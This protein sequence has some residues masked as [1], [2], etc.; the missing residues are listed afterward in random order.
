MLTVAGSSQ[1]SN[2]DLQASG[3][4]QIVFSGPLTYDGSA[5]GSSITTLG[6]ESRIDLSGLTSFA[7]SDDP[8]APVLVHA[9]QNGQIKLAGPLAGSIEIVVDGAGSQV[10]LSSITA[11]GPGKLTAQNDAQLSLP[12]TIHE[13]I[14]VSIFADSTHKSIFHTSRLIEQQVP[15]HRSNGSGE[16]RRF[17]RLSHVDGGAL[18]WRFVPKRAAV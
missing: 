8:M 14:D 12:Q 3:G 2:V 16:R 10:D 1:L 9:T 5:G 11:Y 13:L 6:S 18:T 15:A 7:G 4:A 17:I